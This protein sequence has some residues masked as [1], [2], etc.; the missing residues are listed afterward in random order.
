MV[1]TEASKRL[2]NEREMRWAAEGAISAPSFRCECSRPDCHVFLTV[3]DRE[4]REI[5]S[6]P[7]RF[8]VAPGHAARPLEA[9]VK[10]Y[11]HFSLV[12]KLG[13][14]GILAAELA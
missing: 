11:P 12:E 4:W 14:A 10:E 1:Y 6:R 9:T 8:A 2:R 5:R 7:N 13:Q 3:S